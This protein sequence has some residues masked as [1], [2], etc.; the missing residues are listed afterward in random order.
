MLFLPTHYYHISLKP[1]FVSSKSFTLDPVNLFPASICKGS[2]EIYL[3]GY[4]SVAMDTGNWRTTSGVFERP[5]SLAVASEMNE[6]FWLRN[7]S[8]KKYSYSNPEDIRTRS[9]F[10]TSDAPTK[11]HRIAYWWHKNNTS[12]G[13]SEPLIG[14]ET[15]ILEIPLNSHRIHI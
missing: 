9:C 12:Y 6:I 13:I 4:F 1:V 14:N 3:K 7:C 10:K 11:L 8:F 15:R 2:L 5:S